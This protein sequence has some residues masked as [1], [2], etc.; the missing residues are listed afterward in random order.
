M[1]FC[2]YKPRNVINPQ[3]RERFF[4]RIFRGSMILP[5]L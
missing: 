1:K 3:K 2:S 5:T 4:L